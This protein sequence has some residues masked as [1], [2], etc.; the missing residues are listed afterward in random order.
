VT[1]EE[2][3]LCPRDGTALDPRNYEANVEVDSCSTCRGMWLD[4]GELESIQKSHEQDHSDALIR[5]ETGIAP[6]NTPREPIA[7]PV[8]GVTMESREYAYC[9]GVVVDACVEGCGL[10]LDEGE[11]QALERFFERAQRPWLWSS[12][13][14][15]LDKEG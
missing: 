14:S 11:V 3:L 5:D 2:P 7:C 4:A 1:D 12:L 8:C 10:W 13:T 15:L 6:S 9:S